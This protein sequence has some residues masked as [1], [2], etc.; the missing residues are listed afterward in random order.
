MKHLEGLCMEKLSSVPLNVLS[1]LIQHCKE[2]L[3]AVVM[4]KGGHTKYTKCM[5]GNNCEMCL[6]WKKSLSS[7]RYSLNKSLSERLGFSHN[8]SVTSN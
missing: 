6:S 4:A 2:R 7:V 1:Y 5:A 3:N 8:L